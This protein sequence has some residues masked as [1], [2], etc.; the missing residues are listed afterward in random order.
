M[1]S[2]EHFAHACTECRK[3]IAQQLEV[4]EQL[5]RALAQS[6]DGSAVA[7]LR[8]KVRKLTADTERQFLKAMNAMPVGRS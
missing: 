4:R 7:V 3:L 5:R 6:P 8:D 1:S 2:T